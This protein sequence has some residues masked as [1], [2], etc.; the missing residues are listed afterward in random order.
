M[1]RKGSSIFTRILQ[2]VLD[3]DS[4]KKT[5]RDTQKALRDATDPQPAEQNL[6]RVGKAFGK[7][8]LAALAVA[9][10]LISGLAFALRKVVAE[11]SE[12][13]K[14]LAQ[15]QAVLKSTGQAAGRTAE[16]LQA[17]AAALQKVT[18]FSD[19]AVVAAQNLLLTF[20][21]LRGEEFDKTVEL[22]LDLATAMGTDASSAALQL[23]KALDNPIA[24]LTALRRA[25]VS[26]S[27]SQKDTIKQ[28]VET[29]RLAEAQRLI[30]KELEVQFGG[31]AEAA[32]NTL[33]GALE[34]LR[35]AWGDLFEVSQ[36]S[37]QGIIAAINGIADALPRVR[38]AFDGFFKR[39][40]TAG[41]NAAVA[42][43]RFQLIS[44]QIV[45]FTPL[46][47]VMDMFVR[48][49]E[50][51]RQVDEA[52]KNL[53][54]MIQ[55]RDEIVAEMNNPSAQGP[56]GQ[57]LA[58]IQE[59]EE[60]ETGAAEAQKKAAED[61]LRAQ[62]E[63][64][65]LLREAQSLGIATAQ[66]QNQLRVIQEALWATL[67]N[68]N[69]ALEERIRLTK[70]LQG[71]NETFLAQARQLQERDAADA[72]R[73]GMAPLGRRAAGGLIADPGQPIVAP[74]VIPQFDPEE[75]AKKTRNAWVDAFREIG[76]EAQIASVFM[77]AAFGSDG[78]LASLA[79]VASAK[80]KENLARAI[81][82]AAG[83][84]AALVFGDPTKI[85][86][87]AKASAGFLAAAAAWGALGATGGG[88]GAAGGFGGGGGFRP[89]APPGRLA[90]RMHPQQN[91]TII[92]YIDGIDP[93]NGAHQVKVGEANVQFQQ[94]RGSRL[95]DGSVRR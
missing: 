37:S 72:L 54:A 30:L 93:K 66:E 31:S 64:I 76:A 81:E 91:I 75:G 63:Q 39:V 35:N 47:T 42:L 18:T 71:I 49:N 74:D 73:R 12:S 57:T 87:A 17:Q 44:A 21:R 28:L 94:R 79:R 4:V 52:R 8:R 20:R 78:F 38:D 50:T 69:L 85:A 16:Q 59:I 32:R 68:G 86:P 80:A 67:Q 45:R 61:R 62:M 89:S 43:A 41:A 40:A 70:I 55:A 34:G 83:G 3:R 7:L 65:E 46:G 36:Q 51:K 56:V 95:T 82:T 84:L 24:G 5:E 25:G 26:F 22:T 9:T 10:A 77:Q 88:G 90:D 92:Q 23:G 48:G 6:G 14:A 53:E 33:G 15:Q 58:L 11:S 27:E 19:D 2:L 29:G 1:A 60:A 13:Q